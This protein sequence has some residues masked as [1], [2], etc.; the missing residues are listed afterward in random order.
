[1]KEKIKELYLKADREES[2]AEVL[3]S[4]LNTLH[5]CLNEELE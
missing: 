2:N 1:M 3:K 5:W 4:Q